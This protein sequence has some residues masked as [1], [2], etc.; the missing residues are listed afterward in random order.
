[1]LVV[2]IRVVGNKRRRDVLRIFAC[3]VVS[4]KI[5]GVLKY[6][7]AKAKR[8]ISTQQLNSGLGKLSMLISKSNSSIQSKKESV[9][10]YFGQFVGST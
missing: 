9:L 5:A 10:A 6:F 3:K 1:M 7:P 8:R 2:M 4:L